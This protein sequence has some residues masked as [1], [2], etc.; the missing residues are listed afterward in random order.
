MLKFGKRKWVFSIVFF[1]FFLM[2]T[3]ACCQQVH[4]S[5][6]VRSAHHSSWVW[7]HC[8]KISMLSSS[9]LV[10][11]AQSRRLKMNMW[12]VSSLPPSLL[13]SLPPALPPSLLPPPPSLHSSVTAASAAQG[14]I[15]V[16]QRRSYSFRMHRVC[17]FGPG[18]MKKKKWRASI[19]RRHFDIL[20]ITACV[21]E[22]QCTLMLTA[23]LNG[24]KILSFKLKYLHSWNHLLKLQLFLY[25]HSGHFIRYTLQVPHT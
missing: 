25:S 17:V 20:D 16:E 22:K 2:R 11:C 15:T 12:G 14:G 5:S 1:F 4:A 8:V 23:C 13:L 18:F 3:S 21:A 10:R 6:L 7:H 9:A 19:S 24:G